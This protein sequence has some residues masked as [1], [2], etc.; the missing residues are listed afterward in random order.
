MTKADLL[1]DKVRLTKFT[2]Q[3]DFERQ[4]YPLEV[5][6][7]SAE[8]GRAQAMGLLGS[9]YLFGKTVDNKERGTYY[10]VD[11]DIPEAIALFEEAVKTSEPVSELFLGECY[12]TGN[13]VPK[14]AVRAA[15]LWAESAMQGIGAAQYNMGELYRT[16]QGVKQDFQKAL[17]KYKMAAHNGV[18]D[19]FARFG[20]YSEIGLCME[21]DYLVAFANYQQAAFKGSVLGLFNRAR[22]CENAIGTC[23]DL[24]QAREDYRILADEKKHVPSMIRLGNLYLQEY[25]DDKFLGDRQRSFFLAKKYLK[26]AQDYGS[27]EAAQQL[28]L[29][30]SKTVVQDGTAGKSRSTISEHGTATNKQDSAIS[31]HKSTISEQDDVVGVQEDARDKNN[32]TADAQEGTT[33]K[34]DRKVIES[35]G[36]VNE[37]KGAKNRSERAV[38]KQE[39]IND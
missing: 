33:G 31:E 17:N 37:N 21:R 32:S 22:C 39:Y 25:D 12:Y 35:E 16:G 4:G 34:H 3:S 9:F 27:N 10:I 14:D 18:G 13:G 23:R 11:Q 1:A 8:A 19:A 28:S 30:E 29:L 26:M 15:Q 38:T 36:I 2:L 6:I 24:R 20:Q 5:L 7:K